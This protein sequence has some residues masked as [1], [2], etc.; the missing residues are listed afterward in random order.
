MI[1]SFERLNLLNEYSIRFGWLVLIWL[2][3]RCDSIWVMQRKFDWLIGCIGSVHWVVDWLFGLLIDS[4]IVYSV[5][6][7]IDLWWLIDLSCWLLVWMNGWLNKFDLDPWFVDLVV[8]DMIRFVLL[9]GC[10]IGWQIWFAFFVLLHVWICFSLVD[11]LV[12]W[13]SGCLRDCFIA[14]LFV[15]VFDLVWL[16][17]WWIWFELICVSFDWLKS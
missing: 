16:Y 17:D 10:L 15:S 5:E 6:W 12:G 7:L 1:D 4:M 13:L 11:R 8:W 2:V 14:C 3:V 9:I